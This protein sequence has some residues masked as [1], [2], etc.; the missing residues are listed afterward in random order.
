MRLLI[1]KKSVIIT[2]LFALLLLPISAFSH[3]LSEGASEGIFDFFKTNCKAIIAKHGDKTPK[4]VFREL[5]PKNV[6]AA[7]E[8]KK[9]FFGGDKHEACMKDAIKKADKFFEDCMAE[10]LR[11]A[12]TAIKIATETAAM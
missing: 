9:T 8:G 11:D 10:E 1:M 2:S 7:D 4:E 5:T 6:C 3:E 12:T